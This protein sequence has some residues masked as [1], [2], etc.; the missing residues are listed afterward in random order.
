M[1]IG[2]A[3]GYTS[4]MFGNFVLYREVECAAKGDRHC[5]I[6]GR[7]VDAWDDAEQDLKYFQPESLADRLLELQTQVEQLCAPRSA[8]PM[9]TGSLSWP[10]VALVIRN[11]TSCSSSSSDLTTSFDFAATSR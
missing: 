1:Q 4:E 6:V 8:K 11:F 5:R 10:I 7:T 2:Y 3:A 9:A